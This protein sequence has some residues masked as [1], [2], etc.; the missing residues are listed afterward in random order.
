MYVVPQVL[1]TLVSLFLLESPTSRELKGRLGW[2]AIEPQGVH[3]S[4]PPWDYRHEPLSL[5]FM[6][7][8]CGKRFSHGDIPLA[9]V[10]CGTEVFKPELALLIA[11]FSSETV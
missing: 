4:P 11:P 7:V 8:L 5:A 9:P 1:P 6:G 2:L 10:F 3:V